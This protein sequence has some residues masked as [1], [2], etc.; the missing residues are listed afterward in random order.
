MGPRL[1]MD[2]SEKRKS[3]S[4]AG[5][6]TSDPPVSSLAT[7]ESLDISQQHVRHGTFSEV[8]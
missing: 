8:C 2:V 3:S 6:R 1:G 4:P 7:I 5:I